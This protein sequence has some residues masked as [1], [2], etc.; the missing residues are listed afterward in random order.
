MGNREG[1]RGAEASIDASSP[2]I[3]KTNEVDGTIV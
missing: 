3:P 1:W 2:R